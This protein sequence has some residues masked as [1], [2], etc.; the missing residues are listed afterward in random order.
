MLSLPLARQLKA[1][2]LTW[3]P[4]LHDFFAIPD[5][6]L[7]D[8]VFVI[9]DITVFVERLLGYPVV[10]FHGT[11]E[12]ALDYVML[13]ELVWLPTEEQLREA[14]VE[15][16][17]VRRGSRQAGGP[18]PRLSFST[19]EDGY[20]CTIQYRGQELTFES[21]GASETWAT[22]LLYVLQSETRRPNAQDA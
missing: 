6:Q 3:T 15:R 7:D 20:R 9:S 13:T 2:G 12:W 10:T 11:A 5:R 22:A 17:A 14:L 1:A 8:R 4:R 19:T 16:L 18:Q 21:F